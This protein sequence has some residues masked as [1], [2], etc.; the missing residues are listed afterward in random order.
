MK[1]ETPRF[2]RKQSGTHSETEQHL[3]LAS[4]W[5]VPE[6]YLH[7]LVFFPQESTG[8]PQ[9]EYTNF[10]ASLSVSLCFF[11]PSV[12]IGTEVSPDKSGSHICI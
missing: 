3:H 5:M 12:V 2:D 8:K 7:Q 6:H 1:K 11:A 10:S 4:S 9:N